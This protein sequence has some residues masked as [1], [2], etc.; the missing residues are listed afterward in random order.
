L[1]SI[2]HDWDDAEA[3]RILRSVA[4]KA[5]PGARLFVLDSVVAPGNDPDG[6]KWLDLLMLVLGGRERTEPEWR[7]LFEEQGFR[8][9]HCE[10]GFIE[11][12]C[13]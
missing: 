4:T 13:P 3:V 10:D 8:V 7:S 5:R 1:S 11:T 6:T 2:L 12:R 9:V